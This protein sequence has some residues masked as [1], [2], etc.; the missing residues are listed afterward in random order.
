MAA[1]EINCPACGRETLLRREP[2]F[3]GL[4]KTGEALSCASCG[5]LFADESQ[6]P[7]KSAPQTPE[8]FDESDRSPA[9]DVFDGDETRRLC[10]HCAHYTVNPFL[11]WC[12]QHRREVEATDT[13]PDF[14]DGGG[15]DEEE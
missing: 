5:H 6:I 12:A 9:A 3:E 2:C 11:Q 7:Y 13:C 10:R 14:E 1:V 8:L 4:R 15:K